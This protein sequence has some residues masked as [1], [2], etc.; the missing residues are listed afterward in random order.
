MLS[1]RL[2]HVL[3]AAMA[4]LVIADLASNE[5]IGSSKGQAATPATDVTILMPLGD[6]V[7][8]LR[9]DGRALAS[10]LDAGHHGAIARSS[11]LSAAATLIAFSNYADRDGGRLLLLTSAALAEVARAARAPSGAWE[12]DEA[13]DAFAA[14]SRLQPLAAISAD[15]IAIGVRRGAAPVSLPGLVAGLGRHSGMRVTGIGI[16]AASKASLAGLVADLGIAGRVPYRS[17]PSGREA[18]LALAGD[19]VDLVLAPRSQ[20]LG[21]ARRGEIRIVANGR[22]T[23]ARL[24]P[25]PWSVLVAPSRIA[26]GVQRAL[27]LRTARALRRSPW[28]HHTATRE[29]RPPPR[30]ADGLHPFVLR[31]A[32]RARRL[33]TLAASVP[34][35][36]PGGR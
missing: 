32:A 27:R 30:A 34:E 29:L 4:A 12:A 33:A 2:W 36:H 20:M 6:A 18:T 9:A 15:S 13:R 7:S 31:E 5:L 21:A 10:A 1:E 11:G 26:P 22:A 8:P 23:G 28:M 17:F 14:L 24:G 35:R 16:D 3:L 19:S 25:A